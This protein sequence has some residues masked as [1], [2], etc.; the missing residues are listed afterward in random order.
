MLPVYEM[1]D[2]LTFLAT[3]LRVSLQSLGVCV[4]PYFPH[5]IRVESRM[6]SFSSYCKF[7]RS[8]C[9]DGDHGC[10]IVTVRMLGWVVASTSYSNGQS[11]KAESV[12]L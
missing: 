4:S 2:A 10:M 3:Q 6:S 11:Y 1:V 8:Y 7:G 5:L 9:I 12:N